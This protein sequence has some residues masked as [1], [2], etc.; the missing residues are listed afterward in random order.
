MT[1]VRLDRVTKTF[2]S[3]IAVND[4]F[5]PRR[6]DIRVFDP[7]AVAGLDTTMWR[8]YYDRRPAALFLQLAALMRRQFHFP[9][10]RSLVDR[11]LQSQAIDQRSAD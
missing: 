5:G 11:L 1:A 6:T 9:L 2:G 10:L 3:H 4:L 7:D 8:S